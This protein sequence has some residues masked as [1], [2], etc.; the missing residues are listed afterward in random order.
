LSASFS[1]RIYMNSTTL[2]FFVKKTIRFS[3]AGGYMD[4]TVNPPKPKS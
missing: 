4:V 3:A 1:R 2:S